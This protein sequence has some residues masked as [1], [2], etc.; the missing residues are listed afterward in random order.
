MHFYCFLPYLHLILQIFLCLMRLLL[1]S[2]CRPFRSSNLVPR[3]AVVG[4]VL[5]AILTDRQ[6]P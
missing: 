1:F 5:L 6:Q 2:H 3:L 4:V